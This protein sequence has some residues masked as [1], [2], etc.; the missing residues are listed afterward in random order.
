MRK[1]RSELV[2]EQKQPIWALLF[3]K[4]FHR[5]LFISF[6]REPVI[7]QIESMQSI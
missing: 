4:D 1:A 2:L 3:D 6:E 5:P 7:Y